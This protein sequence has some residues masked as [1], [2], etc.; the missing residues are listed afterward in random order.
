MTELLDES[1]V[2][3]YTHPRVRR[4]MDQAAA[5][6]SVTPEARA[7]DLYYAVRD[8]INYE[9]F[10]TDLSRS[11][12]RASS[13]VQTGKGFCLHKSVLYVSVCRAAGIPARL[14]A[15]T[16]EN[17]LSTPELELLVG[18]TTF[19]HWYAEIQLHDRWIKVTPVFGKLLCRIYGIAPLEFDATAD[20]I[21]QVSNHGGSMRFL[22]KPE[23]PSTPDHRSIVDLVRHHHPLMVD[24][25]GFVPAAGA[26]PFGSIHPTL[27]TTHAH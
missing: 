25:T 24:G 15:A 19:L 23:L 12:L 2:Y 17:H 21:H 6:G 5:Q 9:V 7:R 22:T 18:G 4:F 11:G 14:A 10:G 26:I 1:E 13:V 16:V 20:S 3:D 8:S 27:G